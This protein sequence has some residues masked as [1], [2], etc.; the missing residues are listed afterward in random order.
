MVELMIVMAIIADLCVIAVPSFY[1]AR[2]TTQNARLTSDLRVMAEGFEMYAAEN[3]K[4]PPDADVSVIPKG[5]TQYLRLTGFESQNSLGGLWD[6]DADTGYAKAAICIVLPV[7]ADPIQ[8]EDIDE[9]I[10][11]GV[12]ATGQFRERSPRRFAYIIE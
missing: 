6:Y 10:D 1:R 3:L 9:R 11:N 7:D 12:L 2:R 8:M 5:M 4:Y